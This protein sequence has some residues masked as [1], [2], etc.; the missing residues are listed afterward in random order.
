MICSIVNFENKITFNRPEK[1]SLFKKEV[2]YYENDI[3]A[4]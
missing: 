2:F 4:S 1:V 3:P